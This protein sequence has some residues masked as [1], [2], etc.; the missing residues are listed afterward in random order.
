MPEQQY[1]APES[2]TRLEQRAF[3]VGAVALG[4]ATFGALRS[5][6]TFYASYLMSFLLV[7]GLA[8]GS[9]GLVMLQ[10][11]TSGHWGIIIRRPLE[12][13]TRTLPLL[14]VLFLPIAISGM[15]YLYRAWLDPEELHKEPL[16]KFQQGYLTHNGYLL[17]ALIYLAVCLALLFV[18]ALLAT[19]RSAAL[20]PCAHRH[21][22][23]LLAQLA[24]TL[25]VCAM[26]YR[27]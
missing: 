24:I 11:L 7:L 6:E 1:S 19:Q 3:I 5:P 18:F 10:H 13:A 26:R 15:K 4:L 21:L 20:W 9:L 25:Y 27:P 8:L 17:R 22:L 12:S 2:V 23:R 14:V 16:S